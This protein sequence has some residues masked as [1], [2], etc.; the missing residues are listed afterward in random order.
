M[1]DSTMILA[2]FPGKWVPIS[3]KT[4]EKPKENQCPEH[5]VTLG[6]PL[7]PPRPSS[8]PPVWGTQGRFRAA[9]WAVLLHSRLPGWHQI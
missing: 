7:G 1:D 5:L 6:A 9:C 4:I 3:R 8:W 2:L